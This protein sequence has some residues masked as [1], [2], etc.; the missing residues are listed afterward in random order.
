[1]PPCSA[2]HMVHWLFEFGP[3]SSG[4][5]GETPV[6]FADIDVWAACEAMDLTAW[7][8]RTLR[9]MSRDY[10]QECHRAKDRKCFPP[11]EDAGIIKTASNMSADALRN[12]IRALTQ[13]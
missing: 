3:V 5:M 13:L 11:W 1:M 9:K 8:A 4:P 6:S 12:S 2:L 7:Q 10:I